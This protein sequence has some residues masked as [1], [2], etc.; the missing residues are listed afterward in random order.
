[1]HLWVFVRGGYRQL[2][3][4]LGGSHIIFVHFEE[5]TRISTVL[6]PI[7]SP[8]RETSIN[9]EKSEAGAADD[10]GEEREV[11][12]FSSSETRKAVLN[13]RSTMHF[14]ATVPAREE[15]QMQTFFF[16]LPLTTDTD[17]W[18]LLNL[19]API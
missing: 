3:R 10:A 9:L 11:T 2:A 14:L 12:Y 4:A 17:S 8:Q 15:T 19:Y 1:M 5:F 6:C 13:D 7:I 18:T 16:F